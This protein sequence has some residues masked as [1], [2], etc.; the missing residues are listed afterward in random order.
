MSNPWDVPS[1]APLRPGVKNEEE[2][3]VAVGRALS[4]WEGLEAEMGGVYA[5]LTTGPDERYIA[6]TIRAFGTVTSTGS[7]AEMIAHAAEAFFHPHPAT[8]LEAELKD[9]LKSYRGWA[10]RRN[11]TAHGCSTASDHPDYT[12]DDQPIVTTYCLC[13]SHGHSR[14]WALSME[15]FYHY[16]PHEIEAFGAAFDALGQRVA[17]FSERLDACRKE[18]EAEE[19]G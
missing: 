13:P 6:P 2:L 1:S 8:E 19:I 5:A 17:D 14:K 11:D 15:P 7:R 10:G 4:R 16:I 9:I 3:F 12:D 18:Q